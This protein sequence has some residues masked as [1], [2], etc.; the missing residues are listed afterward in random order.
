VQEK[1]VNHTG[2]AEVF[3]GSLNTLRIFTLRDAPGEPPRVPVA[4]QRIGRFS[5][6]PLDSFSAGGLL[7][8]VDLVSGELSEAVGPVTGR[9]RD[10]HTVHPDTGVEIRGRVV[11]MLREALDLTVRAM[12]V[13]PEALY[14]G[15]DVAVSERGPVLIEG[16]ATWPASRSVQAHGPFA[17]D[18]SCRAFF[19]RYGFLPR[20]VREVGPRSGGTSIGIA[21]PPSGRRGGRHPGARVQPGRQS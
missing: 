16:N 11:P 18:P 8:R 4:V 20:R 10:T 19:Q 2:I 1:V 9:S 3:P 7:A 17:G 14:I 21:A 13:F 5:T 12:E 15:W 6:A